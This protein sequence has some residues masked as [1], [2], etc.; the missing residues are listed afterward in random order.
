VGVLMGNDLAGE[1][2]KRYRKIIKGQNVYVVVGED[3]AF[4]KVPYEN[5]PES[6]DLRVMADTL[7][8]TITGGLGGEG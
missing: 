3:W 2:C 1:P 7:C 4:A 5:R 8:D 6:H